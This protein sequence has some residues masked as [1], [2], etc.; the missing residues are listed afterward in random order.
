MKIDPRKLASPCLAACVLA[1]ASCLYIESAE[2]HRT[3]AIDTGTTSVAVGLEP[4][5][6]GGVNLDST[7]GSIIDHDDT[8]NS[9][10]AGSGDVGGPV[11]CEPIGMPPN[12]MQ[13]NQSNIP[14]CSDTVCSLNHDGSISFSFCLEC[15]GGPPPWASCTIAT[16]HDLSRFD[17]DSGGSG[18]L[19]VRLEVYAPNAAIQLDG[20]L[21]LWYGEHPWR[22]RMPLHQNINGG[23]PFLTVGEQTVYLSSDEPCYHGEPPLPSECRWQCGPIEDPMCER[24]FS[25]T[26]LQLTAENCQPGG[27]YEGTVILH[28]VT[29]FQ[30]QCACID[31]ADCDHEHP[32]CRFGGLPNPHCINGEITQ[33]PNCGGVC[34]I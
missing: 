20:E 26:M 4:S 15:T 17:P 12:Y 21:F 32:T 5:S 19:G 30:P 6:D 13:L 16:A 7:T 28:G 1:T 24:D 29:Y 34:T 2:E 27:R 10:G 3:T 23:P 22:K 9:T 11:G 31:D 8:T 25:S 14:V 33:N 18:A